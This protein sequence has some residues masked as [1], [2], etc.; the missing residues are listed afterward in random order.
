VRTLNNLLFAW[1]LTQFS[2]MTW[3]IIL[4]HQHGFGAFSGVLGFGVGGFECLI[5]AWSFSTGQLRAQT[6]N[7]W[8]ITKHNI[9]AQIIAKGVGDLEKQLLNEWWS[10]PQETINEL[11]D[12]MPSRVQVVI[13]SQRPHKVLVASTLS[14][15]L[16]Y[17]PTLQYCI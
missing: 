8:T 14:N 12:T 9:T 16:L 1:D 17:G 10:I 13:D 11:I 2:R 5:G 3:R 7:L 6:E 15:F 4:Y